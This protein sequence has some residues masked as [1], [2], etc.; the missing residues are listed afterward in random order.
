M[1]QFSLLRA[2]QFRDSFLSPRVF[3]I[4]EPTF[5]DTP[6]IVCSQTNA[7]Y[8]PKHFPLKINRPGKNWIPTTRASLSVFPEIGNSPLYTSM[9]KFEAPAD[10]IQLHSS[11]TKFFHNNYLAQKKKADVKPLKSNP[12]RRVI[13]ECP[14]GIFGGPRIYT[15]LFCAR[16]AFQS[17]RRDFAKRA[18]ELSFKC[19][20][21]AP[22]IIIRAAAGCDGFGKNPSAERVTTY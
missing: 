6:H 14:I 19:A 2:Y 1:E 3:S 20:L 12:R 15:K 10:H 9:S 21:C 22:K 11:V 16:A 17:R 5:L 8:R 4:E 18:P 13:Q 7:L